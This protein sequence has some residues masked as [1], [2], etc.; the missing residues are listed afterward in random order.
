VGRIRKMGRWREQ[1]GARGGRRREQSNDEEVA[2]QHRSTGSFLG[3]DLGRGG[4]N[5]GNSG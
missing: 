3:S 4:G 1:G 5:F 2:G